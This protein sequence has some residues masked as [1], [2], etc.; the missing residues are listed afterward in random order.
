MTQT[1][2]YTNRPGAGD[3]TL[4]FF[5]RYAASIPA[6]QLACPFF[7]DAS[8]VKIIRQAGCPKVQLLVRLCESTSPDALIEARALRGVDVRYYTSRAFHAKFYILGTRALVGSANLTNSGMMAN[9]E[10]SIV[11]DA[12]DPRFDELPGYFDE[13][14]TAPPAA[15]LTPDALSRFRDW[16]RS[17]ARSTPPPLM[18]IDTAAPININVQS[19]NVSVARTYLESFKS[20]YHETLIPAY[21]E[22][23]ELYREHGVRHPD[24]ETFP[25][26]YEL[27][28][29]LFWARGFV[30]DEDLPKQPIRSGEDRK[31]NIRHHV[32]DWF[33]VGN[34]DIDGERLNRIAALQLLFAD[35]DKLNT[36]T[37]EEITDLL[38]GCMA[39]VEMLRF[40]KGGLDAHLAMF[41]QDNR[42][43]DIRATFH[44]LAFGTGDFVQRLYDCI[45]MS[46][47]K[48]AHWGRNCTLELFG[49]VNREDAPP[50][51]G[52]II[53]ALRYL[54]FDV[55]V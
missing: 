37:I 19:Q 45:Y 3:F 39:F 4:N 41:K 10:L 7:T 54:G 14:W 1:D 51:N 34:V 23:R 11:L 18:G 29:F 33:A 13:L 30:T 32:D 47:Y 31:A 28:R 21:R 25:E 24:F 12:S 20:D 27:D 26:A 50:F 16:S 53:K 15:I 22:V 48:L 35:E 17:F 40:T 43:E 46:R 6:A 38:Q 36:V 44:H 8:A 55:A 42:I 2:I 49:W 5:S 52:R 9:R